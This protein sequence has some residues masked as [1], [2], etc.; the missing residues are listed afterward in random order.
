MIYSRRKKAL[1][2]RWLNREEERCENAIKSIVSAIA[3][4][5]TAEKTAIFLTFM[6]YLF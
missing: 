6:R 2:L 1:R 5:L 3:N 4:V